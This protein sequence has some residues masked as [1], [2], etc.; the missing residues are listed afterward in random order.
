MSR[1][2]ILN[3][4]VEKTADYEGTNFHAICL[5]AV[6]KYSHEKVMLCFDFRA[7]SKSPVY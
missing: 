1:L 3:R 5:A 2:Q 4:L 7:T 6:G